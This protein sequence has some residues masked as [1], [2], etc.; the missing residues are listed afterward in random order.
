M[1]YIEGEELFTLLEKDQSFC[2]GNCTEAFIGIHYLKPLA[3][4]LEF[5]HEMGI[6]FHDLKL[7]N[8]MV[9]TEWELKVDLTRL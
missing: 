3:E 6:V 2:K 1:E 4:A 7:E 9:T 8:L 5:L